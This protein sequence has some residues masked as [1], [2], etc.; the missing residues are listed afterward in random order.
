MNSLFYALV[1][2]VT[3]NP[4]GQFVDELRRE[5][6]PEAAHLPA[7]LSILPPRLLAGSET[8]ALELIQQ[9]CNGVQPFEV[10]MGDV[11]HFIPVTP[12]VFI[13]VAHAAYRMRELHEKLD[14]G[15]LRYQEPWIYMPHLTIFRMDDTERARRAYDVARERWSGYHNTRRILIDSLTF[16]R[17][18]PQNRW[19]DLAPIRLGSRLAPAGR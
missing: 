8:E 15:P 10:T 1:A 12:T 14:T 16:V 2:Y 13:R 5:L 3:E 9:V 18:E 11:E 7:H 6:Q 4:I 17:Q 19:L